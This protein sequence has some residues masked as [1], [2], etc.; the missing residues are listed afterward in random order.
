MVYF[1]CEEICPR[2]ED[3][4]ARLFVSRSS[5]GIIR[6]DGRDSADC[7]RKLLDVWLKRSSPEQPLPSWRGLCDALS[8]LDQSLSERIS[9]EHQCSCSLCTGAITKISI[10]F[11]L[12]EH[13]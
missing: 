6:A 9:S 7:L 13:N 10:Y 8:N 3:L 11:E 4:A 2:W 12:Y 5:V 1:A